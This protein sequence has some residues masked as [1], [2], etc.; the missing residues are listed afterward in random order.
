[1]CAENDVMHDVHVNVTVVNFVSFVLR[2][3]PYNFVN[4]TSDIRLLFN[5]SHAKTP[6][7]HMINNDEESSK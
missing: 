6:K 3:L 7:K 2:K 1:L 5:K 4:M